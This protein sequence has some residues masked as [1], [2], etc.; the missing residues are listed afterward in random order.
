[1]KM[2][3]WHKLWCKKLPLEPGKPAAAEALP[4][5][6]VLTD[7]LD[8]HGFFPEQVPE[9]IQ[10]FIA[11]AEELGL[12]SLRIVHGKGKSKLKWVV[13]QELPKYSQVASFRDAPP[14]LGGWGVTLVYLNEQKFDPD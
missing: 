10:A 3:F 11:N 2:N 4:D 14:E 5:A 13:Y 9:M 6:V 12:R 7:L 8:L 1:M